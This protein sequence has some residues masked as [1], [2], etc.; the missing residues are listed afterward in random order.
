M[1]LQK[2][3]VAGVAAVFQDLGIPMYPFAPEKRLR[4]G[5]R[6]FCL[7][8]VSFVKTFLGDHG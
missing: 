5:G 4:L 1:A 6:I 3:P 2:S 7:A 8:S